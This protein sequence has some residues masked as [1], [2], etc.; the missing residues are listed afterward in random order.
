MRLV[1][2]T[3]LLREVS[4]VDDEGKAAERNCTPVAADDS[5]VV[6]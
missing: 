2:V 3:K 6:E 5:V 4:V 1:G